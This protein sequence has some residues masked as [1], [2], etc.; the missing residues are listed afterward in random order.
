MM[1]VRVSGVLVPLLR[2]CRARAVNLSDTVAQSGFNADVT[3]SNWIA[4]KIGELRTAFATVL[5]KNPG[6]L[7]NAGNIQAGITE[8]A[9][10]YSSDRREG[11][12]I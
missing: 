10:A 8:N 2:S 5:N 4:S 11:T 6:F 3:K 12:G 7:A 1:Q 9:F